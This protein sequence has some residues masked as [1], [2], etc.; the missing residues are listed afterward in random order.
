MTHRRAGGPSSAAP[1]APSRPVST[2]S[3]GRI[4]VSNS[5][6]FAWCSVITCTRRRVRFARRCEQSLASAFEHPLV[7]R[8]CRRR[9]PCAASSAE[10]AIG[11]REVDRRR[12]CT[13][14]RPAPATPR[15][16]G[17]RTA[18]TARG[19]RRL[20]RRPTPLE[21]QHGRRPLSASRT[22]ASA[23]ASGSGRSA[24][25]FATTQQVGQHEAAPGRAQHRKPCQPIGGLRER[26][27][28]A[29]A[30]RASPAGRTALRARRPRIDA[31]RAERRQQRLRVA[32]RAHQHRDTRHACF[33]RLD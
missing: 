12:R 14:A 17:L 21:P 20:E 15:A 26:A 33:E 16:H 32:A 30:D 6:P 24:A 29:T 18:A 1:V 3:A 13:R 8:E 11:A 27:A 19:K 28:R 23:I 4:T 7:S 5:R 25:A 9:A 22:A 31:G 10:H 2:S